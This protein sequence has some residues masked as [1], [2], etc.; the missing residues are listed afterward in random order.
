MEWRRQGEHSTF[1]YSTEQN[2][3]EEEQPMQGPAQPLLAQK[4]MSSGKVFRLWAERSLCGC[5]SF[6]KDLACQ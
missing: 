2:D 5:L 4:K 3:K 1:Y 6:R